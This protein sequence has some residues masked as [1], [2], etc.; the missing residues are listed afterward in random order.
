M[1][2]ILIPLVL[3]YGLFWVA[4]ISFFMQGNIV[5]GFIWEGFTTIH[6]LFM[7]RSIAFGKRTIQHKQQEAR[8]EL[9]RITKEEPIKELSRICPFCGEKIEETTSECPHCHT[10]G[11]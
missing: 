5:A 2:L 8:I 10:K 6:F 3:I 4:G 1:K 9:E 7:I 11:L